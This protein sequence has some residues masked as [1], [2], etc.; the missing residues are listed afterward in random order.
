MRHRSAASSSREELGRH[1][2]TVD[3]Q[4]E[5]VSCA[6]ARRPAITPKTGARSS[7][8]SSS[9]GK[10]SAGPSAFPTTST[11]VAD[12]DEGPASP[13]GERLAAKLRE[14]LRRAE[15]L[16][17]AADEQHARGG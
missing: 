12:L 7:E 15:P 13:L 6:A 3:G 9:T 16:R 14:R 5:Q 17:G 4:D 8:P 1:E 11:S 2:R 10:G